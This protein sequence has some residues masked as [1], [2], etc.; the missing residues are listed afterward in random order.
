MTTHNM[1][2]IQ[3]KVKKENL[4]NVEFVAITFDPDRDKA[5][6]LKSFA[7]IRGIDLSNFNFF[8]GDINSIQFLM[9]KFNIVALPGDTTITTSGKLSYFFTHTDRL[10]LVDKNLNIRN[11]YSGSQP[12]IENI[13]NDIK[14]LGN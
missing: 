14:Y 9:K 6:I 4:K 8:T 3:D 1:Q 2:L 5:R 12:N 7:L 10:T 11:T 13:I